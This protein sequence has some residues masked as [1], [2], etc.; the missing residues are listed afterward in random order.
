VLCSSRGER[1]ARESGGEGRWAFGA[2]RLPTV[3]RKEDNTIPSQST[4]RTERRHRRSTALTC[5][6]PLRVLVILV[7]AGRQICRA[8]VGTSTGCLRAGARAAGGW[9]GDGTAG[10]WVPLVWLCPA[11]LLGGSALVEG[12]ASAAPWQHA[13][14]P[15]WRR[16]AA[17]CV[18]RAEARPSTGLAA[19]AKGLD[20]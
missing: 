16:S 13:A 9:T 7:S 17:R 1:P 8:R 19:T 20:R 2:T 11:I 18:G 3:L 12:A 5:G 15:C 4:C 6:A 14:G 10:Q